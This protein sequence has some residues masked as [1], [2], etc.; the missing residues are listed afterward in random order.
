[1][2]RLLISSIVVM[3]IHGLAF[4][5]T[6]PGQK[7]GRTKLGFATASLGSV[8][9]TQTVAMGEVFEK[10]LNTSIF[11]MTT[12]G[13][14]AIATVM[15]RGEADVGVLNSTHSF[16]SYTGAKG[17]EADFPEYVKLGKQPQF[18]MMAGGH[19]IPFGIL[20]RK[21]AGINRLQDLKGKKIFGKV[22]GSVG[23]WAATRGYL[24][25]AGLKPE[26]V[27]ILSATSTTEGAKRAMEGEAHGASI[28]AE[29]PRM[30]EFEATVGGWFLSGPIDDKG[31]AIYKKYW[32]GITSFTAQSDTPCVKKGTTMMAIPT[33]FFTTTRLSDDLAYALTKCF[34]EKRKE[35]ANIQREFDDWSVES[36]LKGA[37]I[38]F[39]AGAI[40]Y[41]KE[42]GAWTPAMDQ[43]QERLIAAAK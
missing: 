34:F 5:G 2:K 13:S 31:M 20:V 11:A 40:K 25:T 32:P 26:D 1:M 3:V 37:S 42:I 14:T 6:T 43:L 28:N 17:F 24:E 16:L 10:Y 35:I 7:V 36:S 23:I 4:A 30:I 41:Y 8:N 12:T 29:G 9:Y 22:L 18:R 33:L 27:T 21:D 38:P 39:H 19:P 15:A